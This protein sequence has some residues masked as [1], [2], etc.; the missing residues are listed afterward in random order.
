MNLT[1]PINGHDRTSPNHVKDISNCTKHDLS[2]TGIQNSLASHS[3]GNGIVSLDDAALNITVHDSS[4]FEDVS[5]FDMNDCFETL[6]LV[7]RDAYITSSKKR[8]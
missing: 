8:N 2:I 5:Q 7:S 4:N 6:S 1:C 3:G